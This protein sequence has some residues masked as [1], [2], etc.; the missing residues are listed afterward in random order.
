MSRKEKKIK[1]KKPRKPS[2]LGR[3]WSGMDRSRRLALG[4]NVAWAVAGAVC[5]VAAVYGLKSLE[6]RVLSG[7]S[8]P[9]P[10]IVRVSIVN[11]PWW[12][13][14]SLARAV[15]A[16]IT[17]QV[18]GF[19]DPDLTSTV[20]SLAQANPWISRV[21]KVSKHRTQDPRVGLVEV[22]A[23]MRR[24]AAKVLHGGKHYY[25]D[26]QGFRLSDEQVPQWVVQ[27]EATPQSPAG[28]ACYA[29]RADIPPKANAS[30]IHH[31]VIDV[32][33]F[34]TPPAVGQRWAGDDVADGLKLI[35]LVQKKPYAGQIATI[36]VRNH[37][38]RLSKREPQIRMLAQA[39]G[40]GGKTTDIRF[41]RFSS[42]P[43]GV[44]VISDDQKIAKLDK[45]FADYGRLAGLNRYIDLR[46][47]QM[48]VSTN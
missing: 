4:R 43:D 27:V 32:G 21:G 10:E 26:D 39:A 40:S 35:Q 44:Y 48:L 24:P 45:Y 16:S 47:D 34:G 17:P 2:A 30:A 33:V 15:E 37:G 25:I 14:A 29:N 31:I 9:A 20:F 13:P 1:E 6:H 7:Q 8:A 41:G 18:A 5:A 38:N 12:I 36:D 46:Y 22:E 19:Y 28:Q 23:D 11:R 3:W 42:A